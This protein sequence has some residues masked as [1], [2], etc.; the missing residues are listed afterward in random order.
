[1]DTAED[2]TKELKPYRVQKDNND[3]QK[4]VHAIKTRMNPFSLES[5]DNLYCV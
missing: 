5:D 2:T 4:L 3:L 1:M